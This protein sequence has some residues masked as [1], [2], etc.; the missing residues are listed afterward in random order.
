MKGNSPALLD[1]LLAI[2]ISIACCWYGLRDKC[3]NSP[4]GRHYSVVQNCRYQCKYCGKLAD[5]MAPDIK[6]RDS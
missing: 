2:P 4:D 5:R 3:S 1:Y 6:G